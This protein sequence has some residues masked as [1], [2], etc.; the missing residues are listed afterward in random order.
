[1]GLTLLECMTLKSSTG[2]YNFSQMI[3]NQELID[4]RI[5]ETKFMYSKLLTNMV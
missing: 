1:M 5:N 2:V 3:I 4:H